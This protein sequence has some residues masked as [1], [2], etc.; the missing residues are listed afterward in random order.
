MM[1]ATTPS[2][3]QSI[4]STIQ[5]YLGLTIFLAQMPA[6][7]EKERNKRLF[8]SN[9]ITKTCSTFI[10]VA[11]ARLFGNKFMCGVTVKT[12]CFSM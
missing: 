9:M 10:I 4:S 1:R 3:C 12:F 2:S 8:I 5:L 6:A 7:Q 11:I